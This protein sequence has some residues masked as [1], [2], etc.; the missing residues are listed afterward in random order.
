MFFLLIET[1]LSRSKFGLMSID[2]LSTNRN[3][4]IKIKMARIL[5]IRNKE[6]QRDP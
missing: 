4:V 1:E 3:S 6:G 5:A 2:V